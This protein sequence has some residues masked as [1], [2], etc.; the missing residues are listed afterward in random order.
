MSAVVAAEAALATTSCEGEGALLKQVGVGLSFNK[1][2][3]AQV[4][5]ELPGWNSR[6]VKLSFLA[7]REVSWQLKLLM[8]AQLVRAVAEWGQTQE[9]HLQ[10]V[11][12]IA[13]AELHCRV[14]D[15][16]LAVIA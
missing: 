10:S 16:L 13:R 9:G 14:A 1:T 4:C 8:Q 7:A 6:G 11:S 2:F 5:F 12:Q 3:V 15:L